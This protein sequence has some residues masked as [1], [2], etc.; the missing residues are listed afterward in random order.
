[1]LHAPDATAA[2]GAAAAT[3][4]RNATTTESVFARTNRPLR[5]A[6]MPSAGLVDK[7]T[8]P[9]GGRVAITEHGIDTSSAAGAPDTSGAVM[10]PTF[11]PAATPWGH[12]MVAVLWV[13][14]SNGVSAHSTSP[15]RPAS[16]ATRRA[17]RLD[18][19]FSLGTSVDGRRRDR[20]G[21]GLTLDFRSG[22]GGPVN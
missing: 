10:S 6:S 20:G 17:I 22:Y 8:P 16:T 1:V 15:A 14:G 13:T 12:T 7:T 19:T 4:S 11:P 2:R 21:S 3:E 9:F 5:V 18:S